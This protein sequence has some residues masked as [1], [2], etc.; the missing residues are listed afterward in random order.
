MTKIESGVDVFGGEAEK[1]EKSLFI[2]RTEKRELWGRV[3]L[4]SS[5][6][7]GFSVTMFTGDHLQLFS[8][9]MLRVGWGLLLLS[10]L[11][12]LFLLKKE[13]EFEQEQGLASLARKWDE[14]DFVLPLKTQLEKDR[15]LALIYLHNLRGVSDEEMPFSALAT[16]IFEAH[17]KSLSSWNMIKNPDKFYS[18]S[19]FQALNRTTNFF[20]SSFVL[21]LIFLVGAVF[22]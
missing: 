16:T 21:A 17:K 4:L 11:G 5:A 22:V 15:Y 19:H 7:L 20:Y 3:I 18:Y 14:A 8:F 6:I 1:L 10:I 2:F 13:S 12:G 9:G